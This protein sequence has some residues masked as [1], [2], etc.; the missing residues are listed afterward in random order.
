VF[1][2][3]V[4]SGIVILTGTHEEFEQLAEWVAAEA[5]HE[6]NRRREKRLD[7]AYLHLTEMLDHVAVSKA[8]F[9][10]G[11]QSPAR[12]RHSDS[13]GQIRGRWRIEDSDLW[14]RDALDLVGPAYVE[15]LLDGTGSFRFIVVEGRMDCRPASIDGR[16]GV[17]FSW[18][19]VDEGVPV[20]GRG[21]A[22]ELDHNRLEFHIF[23]HMGDESSFRARRTEPSSP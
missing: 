8:P 6:P 5:N 3:R 21:W 1:G 23:F 7:D 10:T 16:C 11:A 18:D 4:E 17:E 13:N 14:D 12:R 19:G 9:G 2:G 22:V 15:F 20:S